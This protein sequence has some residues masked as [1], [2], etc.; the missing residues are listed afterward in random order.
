MYGAFQFIV[1]GKWEKFNVSDGSRSVS[2]IL[3]FA[4]VYLE[5]DGKNVKLQKS[6][7]GHLLRLI[8]G[9]ENFT[10]SLVLLWQQLA[11]TFL[12]CMEGQ[13][14]RMKMVD[15]RS[16]SHLHFSGI[17]VCTNN[18]KWM[19]QHNQQL[20]YQVYALLPWDGYQSQVP[21]AFEEIR[22]L[23]FWHSWW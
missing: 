4:F 14:M 18:I 5:M 15:P 20:C 8:H 13:T 19:Q 9:Q 1:H 6:W 11:T 17:H 2:T 21:I 3:M 16:S 12:W 23:F 10:G 22:Q 7:D